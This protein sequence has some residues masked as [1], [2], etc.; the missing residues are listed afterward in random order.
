VLKIITQKNIL[1]NLL[2][3][4]N[5]MKCTLNFLLVATLAVM[6]KFLSGNKRKDRENGG[7]SRK[8]MELIITKKQY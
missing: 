8:T 4:V 7:H 5:V 1:G 6:D 2:K 3:A